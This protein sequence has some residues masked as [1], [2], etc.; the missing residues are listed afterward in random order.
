M[1]TR[2]TLIIAAAILAFVPLPAMA[3][4]TA[5]PPP[6]EDKLLEA[7]NEYLN[8][9][10]KIRRISAFKTMLRTADNDIRNA[11]IT[12]GLKSDEEAIRATALRCKFLLSNAVRIRSLTFAE[13]TERAKALERTLSEKE[14]GLVEKGLSEAY[15]VFYRDPDRNCVSINSH[16]DSRCK[17]SLQASVSNTTLSLVNGRARRGNF[18]LENGRL[19]GEISIWNGGGYDTIPG[20][21]FLE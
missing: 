14:I 8:S 20:E 21:L 18:S 10:S 11:V 13:S 16:H 1:A 9:K 5:G 17:P 3:C 4:E 6:T 2:R 15:P 7:E 19:I 12:D